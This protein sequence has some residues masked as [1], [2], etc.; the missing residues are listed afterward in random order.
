MAHRFEYSI[1]TRCDRNTA[2]DFFTD[3][4]RWNSCADSYGDIRWM[5]G[6]PWEVGSRLE[7]ELTNPGPFTVKQVIIGIVSREKVG[8][9]N[10]AMGIAIEQW[11][12]FEDDASGG[13]K[14]S[15]WL[16]YTGFRSVL[17][18]RPVENLIRDFM[19]TWYNGFR[20]RCDE[21]AA[22]KPTPNPAGPS[23]SLD[24]TL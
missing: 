1:V 10:H 5:E 8:W 7:I 16:D 21:L 19:T 12:L 2:W 24:S 17:F 11:V 20:Q 9:I 3:I 6:E 15:T 18:G 13:T 23:G 4:R 22:S 14:I